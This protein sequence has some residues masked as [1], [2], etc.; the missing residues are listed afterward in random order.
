MSR[1]LMGASRHTKQR[2]RKAESTSFSRHHLDGVELP[3]EELRDHAYADRP[4]FQ[5]RCPC[6]AASHCSLKRSDTGQVNCRRLKYHRRKTPSREICAYLR[7]HNKRGHLIDACPAL[8]GRCPRCACR[9]HSV[10]DGCDLQDEEVMEALFSDFEM[11]ADDGFYTERRW[12]LDPEDS[13][14]WGFFPTN[15]EA[16]HKLSYR[17]LARLP[18]MEG[19]ALVQA[20]GALTPSAV[21]I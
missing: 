15:R 3:E 21:Q 20:T 19:L 13:A 16:A 9:G 18:V 6:C 10:E 2:R 14:A 4:L 5:L 1:N 11:Y 12:D 8:H 7:C 17:H